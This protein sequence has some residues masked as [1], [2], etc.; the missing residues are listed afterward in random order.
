VITQ[1]TTPARVAASTSAPSPAARALWASAHKKSL[2]TSARTAFGATDVDSLAVVNEDQGEGEDEGE[3]AA[4]SGT[5]HAGSRS[6]GES[7]TAVGKGN[8]GNGASP[9]SGADGQRG[10]DSAHSGAM[11]AAAKWLKRDPGKGTPVLPGPPSAALRHP[12]DV[13]DVA[14]GI[15]PGS[16]D[17]PAA[18]A[19]GVA[20]AQPDESDVP[21]AVDQTQPQ[22]ELALPRVMLDSPAEAG[23][24]AQ[25]GQA[26]DA[27]PMLASELTSLI[28][29]VQAVDS[30]VNLL[31]AAAHER[32]A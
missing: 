30:R 1:V 27:E 10:Q 19:A 25:A 7:P 31:I 24:R 3:A 29:L 11:A 9:K 20:P 16:E 4:A 26:L 23:D 14:V 5:L 13:K 2:R 15:Q 28:E 17:A 6:D 21:D 22:H 8:A 18:G 32:G 12:A